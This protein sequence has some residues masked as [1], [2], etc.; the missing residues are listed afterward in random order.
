MSRCDICLSAA[1][2]TCPDCQRSACGMHW[3]ELQGHI[4]YVSHWLPGDYGL[5]AL[6]SVPARCYAGLD[7]ETLAQNWAPPSSAT[8]RQLVRAAF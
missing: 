2:F 1:T 7:I 5:A 4:D 6:V 3:Q 8:E